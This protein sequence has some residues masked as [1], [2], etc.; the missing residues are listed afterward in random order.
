MKTPASPTHDE[1]IVLRCQLGEPAAFAE[2]VREMERPLL[3]YAAKLLCDEDLAL[4]VLQEVWLV[5]FRTIRRLEDPRSVRPWLY[6]ITRSRAV[7][8]IR[9]ERS[10]GQAERTR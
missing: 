7:D 10:R 8:R 3:Y 4:D 5:A 6:R 1:W 2:L 9:S